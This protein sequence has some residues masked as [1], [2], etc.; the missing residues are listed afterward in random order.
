MAGFAPERIDTG[1]QS[2][3]ALMM[4]G[5]VWLKTVEGMT[6]MSSPIDCL[7][8]RIAHSGLTPDDRCGYFG[9]YS[10]RMCENG[11]TQ[12]DSFN[13]RLRISDIRLHTNHYSW[14][15]LYFETTSRVFHETVMPGRTTYILVGRIV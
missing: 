12:T 3:S 13:V 15:L 4:T 8:V 14:E 9:T 11:P 5:N 10:F 6:I 2:G 7:S 1:P